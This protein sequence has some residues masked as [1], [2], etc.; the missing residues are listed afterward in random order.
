MACAICPEYYN[1]MESEY[2]APCPRPN[3]LWNYVY[4]QEYTERLLA[5]YKND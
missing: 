4:H 5:A 1:C 3:G 2:I